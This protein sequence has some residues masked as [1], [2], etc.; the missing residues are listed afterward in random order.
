M[1]DADGG[2]MGKRALSENGFWRRR[3]ARTCRRLGKEG[4]GKRTSRSPGISTHRAG[5]VPV[6]CPEAG[7]TGLGQGLRKNRNIASKS[8][9]ARRVLLWPYQQFQG[10]CG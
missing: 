1:R 8:G 10:R 7:L 3:L 9:D 6:C 2:D 4:E 5:G